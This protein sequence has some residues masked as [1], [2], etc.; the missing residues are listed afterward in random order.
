MSRATRGAVVFRR[1]MPGPGDIK[2][3]AGLYWSRGAMGRLDYD[4]ATALAF[5]WIRASRQGGLSFPP[6]VITQGS[7]HS[8]TPGK[9]HDGGGV[10]DL[11]VRHM[12]AIEKEILIQ[13]LIREAFVVHDLEPSDSGP[14]IHA[15]YT[16]S[17]QLNSAARQQATYGRRV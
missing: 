16:R 11:R 10:V 14:H 6:I 5:A 12:T 1:G 3:A 7:H 2:L 13:A 9:A 15:V 17:T 4:V 8:A